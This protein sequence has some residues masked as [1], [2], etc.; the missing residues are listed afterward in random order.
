MRFLCDEMLGRFARYL[1]AA[2]HDTALAS[3]GT[4]DRDLLERAHREDRLFLTCDRRIAEHRRARGIALILPR[5]NLDEVAC[6][7]TRAVQ[8]DWLHAPFTRCLVDNTPLAAVGAAQL[9]ARAGRRRRARRSPLPGVR[10]HLLG[11][12]APSP[13]AAAPARMG[14][15]RIRPDPRRPREACWHNSDRHRVACPTVATLPYGGSSCVIPFPASRSLSLLPRASL[16]P[17]RPRM[18]I[19]TSRSR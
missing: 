19:P 13:H 12:L 3:G 17:P 10:P 5:G 4:A 14:D 18:P 2:G 1:R 16:R 9:R 11:G 6:A 15:G 8:L 7:V